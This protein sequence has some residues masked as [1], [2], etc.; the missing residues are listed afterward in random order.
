MKAAL[1]SILALLFGARVYAVPLGHQVLDSE[2]Q[3]A[4]PDI[5]SELDANRA[6]AQEARKDDRPGDIGETL[7]R[8]QLIIP[9]IYC[10]VQPGR[11]ECTEL[12]ASE[13]QQD[14]GIEAEPASLRR[15]EKRF[16]LFGAFE[17]TCFEHADSPACNAWN[18]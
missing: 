12:A 5:Y 7:G 2:R 10:K 9:E 13:S 3:L 1:A 17:R 11:P 4:T 15:P 8:R 16:D 6:V 14:G 18:N